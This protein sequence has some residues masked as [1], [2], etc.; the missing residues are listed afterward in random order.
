MPQTAAINHPEIPR[1]FFN[2]GAGPNIP[3]QQGQSPIFIAAMPG[4]AKVIQSLIKIGTD[5]EIFDSYEWTPI[6]AT[7]DCGHNDTI[8]RVLI[9]GGANIADTITGIGSRPLH[10][11]VYK[12]PHVM[13]LLLE[14]AKRL[15]LN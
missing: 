4:S 5:P 2:A 7:V 9:G 10:L 11:A 12:P 3:S 8:L 13:Q 6:C 14:F 1:L 15:D